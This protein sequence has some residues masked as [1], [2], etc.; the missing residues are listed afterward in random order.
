MEYTCREK[1][2]NHTSRRETW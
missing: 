1:H 2:L